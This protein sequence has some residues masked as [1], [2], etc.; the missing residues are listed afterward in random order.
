M[1]TLLIDDERTIDCTMVV[2]IYDEGILALQIEKWDELLLDHDLGDPD[3]RKTGYGIMC[4]L[5]QNVQYIPRRI[6][7][8]TLNPAGRKNMLLVLRNFVAKG[9]CSG[10]I[11]PGGRNQPCY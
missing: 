4:W 8:I 11:N 3:E 9:Y 10:S 5:E 6:I 1:R 7:L 2:R